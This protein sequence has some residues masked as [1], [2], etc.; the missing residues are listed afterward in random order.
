MNKNFGRYVL[1]L[2]LGCFL[3][4]YFLLGELKNIWS[5][6]Q[7]PLFDFRGQWQL[8]AYTLHGIDPYPLRGVEEP[9]IEELGEIPAA[10]STTPWGLILGNFFYP[11]FLNVR[12]AA[13][14][15]LVLNIIVLLITALVLNKFFRFSAIMLPAFL[16]SF[17]ISMHF[18]NAGAVIC[19]FL[20]LSCI[21]ADR[22]PILAGFLLGV[23]MI[24]PQVALPIC[25]A[26][27]FR[28]NFKV[29]TVAALIDFAAWG[30]AAVMTNASPLQLLTEFFSIK[31]GGNTVFSG[32][33]TLAFPEDKS[34]AMGLSML[35]G[36]FFIWLTFKDKEYFWACPACL[37]TTFFA[38]S[39]HNEFFILILPALVAINFAARADSK[40]EK[41]F[42]LIVFAITASA[43]YALLISIKFFVEDLITAFWLARTIFAV[44]LILI[45]FFTAKNFLKI[46]LSASRKIKGRGE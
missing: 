12:D 30:I 11:G 13:N 35:A 38:Y 19:C 1:A 8:C 39:F 2:S 36:I 18:G 6:A 22:L 40:R 31:T 23:A 29:L 46:F 15:F 10:W 25:F 5:V 4:N 44:M 37:A 3:A 17:F 16:A 33:F 34:L 21:F 20:I 27:L 42:G 24:K 41:I 28:K 14:Y 26:L 45:G 9:L 32:L 43:P 7:Y